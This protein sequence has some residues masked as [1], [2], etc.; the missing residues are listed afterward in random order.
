MIHRIKLSNGQLVTLTEGDDCLAIG[1]FD[2][3]D[4][5][6][7]WICT[8]S[9]MGVLVAPNSSHAPEELTSGLSDTS[10][11]DP[12]FIDVELEA[13]ESTSGE[14]ARKADIDK[15]NNLTRILRSIAEDIDEELWD[16]LDGM[17]DGDH[18]G[19]SLCVLDY[20]AIKRVLSQSGG[21]G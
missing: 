12:G 21:I 8:I 14:A 10:G 18:I 19:L 15:A 16:E 4:G 11:L 5:D 3:V 6:D 1:Q 20:K 17:D 13:E 9:P 2:K 7:W